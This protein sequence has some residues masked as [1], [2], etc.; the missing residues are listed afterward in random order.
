MLWKPDQTF[1]PSP[2]MAMEGPRERLGYVATFSLDPK[3][4]KRDAINVLDLDPG[5][6]TFASVVGRLEMPNAGN[7]LHHFGWNACS[8][9]LCPYSPHP[10]V[11]R[12]YLLVP[13]RARRKSSR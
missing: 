10:H 1:Y 3:H 8:A 12:R 7:E 9:A 11:E 13:T 2:R 4:G 5:S 6:P